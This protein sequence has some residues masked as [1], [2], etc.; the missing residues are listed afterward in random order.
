[1]KPITNT[2]DFNE[3]QKKKDAIN[4]KE[5]LAVVPHF[6]DRTYTVNGKTFEQ[7]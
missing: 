4:V 3:M 1:M 2:R 6:K 5:L 7:S